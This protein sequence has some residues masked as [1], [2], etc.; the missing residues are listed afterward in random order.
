MDKRFLFTVGVLLEGA[1]CLSCSIYSMQTPQ[2]VPV[3]RWQFGGA[4]S[5]LGGKNYPFNPELSGLWVRLGLAPCVDVG[6]QTW[7]FGAKLDGKYN[8]IEDY[9]SV[10]LG[11]G[12]SIPVDDGLLEYDGHSI[13]ESSIYTGLP[14]KIIS[15]YL[16]GRAM[17]HKPQYNSAEI[18]TG[19]VIGL[20][21]KTERTISIYLEGGGMASNLFHPTA[22]PRLLYTV[23][24]GI[25]I[26]SKKTKD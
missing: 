24:L 21:Y 12:V 14:G 19:G 23:G 13:L 3:G 20:C 1:L 8:L 11:G 2:T 22:N 6:L 18:I 4:A 5:F 26:H 15:P 17:I 16:T 10:G 7:G 25:S 9:L